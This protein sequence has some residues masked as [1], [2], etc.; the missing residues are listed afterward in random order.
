M[1]PEPPC[2]KKTTIFQENN[3]YTTDIKTNSQNTE[4]AT[5]INNMIQM[6]TKI[7]QQNIQNIPDNKILKTKA[8]EIDK[9]E[10]TLSRSIRVV[11][12]I[13]CWKITISPGLETQN[14]SNGIHLT[15]FPSLRD[16]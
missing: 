12:S 13:S 7:V 14:K 15:T 16:K 10:N 11:G 3:N 9:S 4:P 2:K 6:H 1:Q 5:I 8:S